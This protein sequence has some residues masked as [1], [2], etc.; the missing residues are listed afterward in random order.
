MSTVSKPTVHAILLFQPRE[1]K[2]LVN[3]KA[4]R[5]GKYPKTHRGGSPRTAFAKTCLLQLRG[6]K[7]QS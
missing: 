6:R 3:C 5:I 4:H 7:R 2:M 1:T